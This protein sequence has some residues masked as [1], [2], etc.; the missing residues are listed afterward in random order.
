MD[1]EP[2]NASILVVDDEPML[3]Q[4]L[5]VFL[6]SHRYAVRTA[7][8]G[9]AALDELVRSQPDLVLLDLMLPCLDGIEVCR[10][11][12]AHSEVPIIMLTARDDVGDKVLGLE[13][14]ADDYV[15]K[16]FVLRELL[17]RIRA[18]LRRSYA[19]RTTR[20][21][22]TVSPPGA[23]GW[24]IGDLVI[25][26][27][28]HAVRRAGR[29]VELSPK[30]FR[31]LCVLAACPSTVLPRGQLLSQVWGDE[32]MGDEKTLDVHIRWLREKIERDPSHPTLIRTVRGA[33]YQFM[34]EAGG[35]EGGGAQEVG[36]GPDSGR[37]NAQSV[38]RAGARGRG[39][40][41]E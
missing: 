38:R 14:G 32:F 37:F 5:T 13:W 28:Q 19:S 36:D 40:G 29:T 1:Q 6:E 10:R 31:L 21:T 18:T 34:A 9:P 25:D 4:S 17:A 26:P 7:R 33:G 8:D 3:L 30:E 12:R 2:L 20:T 16:P 24:T 39:P 27:A 22:T 35:A 15:T 11:I 41:P 23:E